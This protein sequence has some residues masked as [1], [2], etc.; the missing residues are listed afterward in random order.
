MKTRKRNVKTKPVEAKPALENAQPQSPASS[1][2]TEN[3]PPPPE[4]LYEMAKGE[5][6][7]RILDEYIGAIQVLRDEKR[8]SF[9]EIAEWLSGNGVE[10][11]HNAVYRAYLR[12]VPPQFQ[13]EFERDVAL[14]EM[15]EEGR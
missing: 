3:S 2:V 9:R 10:T 15:Q 8:F 4:M 12:H 5:E 7:R 11:D 6:D 13:E 1:V 14:E